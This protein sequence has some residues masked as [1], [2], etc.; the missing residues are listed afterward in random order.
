MKKIFLGILVM[1]ASCFAATV[2]EEDVNSVDCLILKDENSIV[3]KYSHER[4]DE[5]KEIKVQWLD[6]EG[7]VSRERNL[8]IQAGHGSIYDFRYID[9]RMKGIWT[10]KVKDGEKVSEGTFELK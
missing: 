7:N 4:I 6:P 2:D 5:D 9:G 10:F 3:C 1:A 8:I